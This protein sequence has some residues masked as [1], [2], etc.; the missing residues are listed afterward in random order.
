MRGGADLTSRILGRPP[1]HSEIKQII[2]H[3]VYAM[4][5]LGTQRH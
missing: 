5:A 4:R 2:D 3:V 1:E